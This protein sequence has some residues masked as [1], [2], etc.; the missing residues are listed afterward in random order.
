MNLNLINPQKIAVSRQWW[1]IVG[2]AVLGVVGVTAWRSAQV[3]NQREE[4]VAVLPEITSVTALGRLEPD[5][6]T[7]ALTA[8]T[9]A[10]ESRIQELLVKEG[11]VVEAGQVIAILDNRD[12]MQAALQK[13]EQQ[14]QIARAQLAQ[15]QAGAQT[16][17]LQ[18]QVAEIAR[19]EADQA[20]NISA[21]RATVARLDAEVQHAQIEA[22]RYGSLYQQ[23]AVSASQRDAKQLTYTTAQRQLQEAQASLGRIESAGQE[24]ITQARA[25]L[26]RIAEV[27]PVDV[28]A[29]EADVQSAIAGVAEAQANLDQAY[30]R[31]PRD[32]QVL[33]IHTRSGE[34]IGD[35]GIATLGHTQQMMVVAE[36][37]QDDIAKVN[38]GQRVEITTPTIDDVLQG[39]VQRIGLQVESQQVVN[40]DPAANIDAKVVEVHIQLDDPDGET[41]ATLTN[42]QVTAAIQI[43]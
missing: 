24:Q 21:Q 14:V 42:L 28:D 25:T 31:S 38:P 32:G 12:R 15:V 39:T 33:K 20:G 34:T 7:I 18:A 26:D 35:E 5:G 16:G 30:V 40:E 2:V 4:Q 3:L 13:A 27:R 8:P 6:E 17:E 36:V 22:Q 11:D 43:K 23:G 37:Y 10:Q 9:S 29:A 1:L 41:V 19:L